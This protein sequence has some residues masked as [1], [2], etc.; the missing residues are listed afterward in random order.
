MPVVSNHKPQTPIEKLYWSF[1]SGFNSYSE[2]EF[3]QSGVFKPHKYPSIRS[4]QDYSIG[5][6]FGIVVGINFPRKE[7]RVGAYFN[8]LDSYRFWHNYGKRWIEEKVDRHLMWKKHKTK[9]S[10][11]YYANADFDENGHNWHEVYKLIVEIMVK[12]KNAFTAE[13]IL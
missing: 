9:A 5:C 7:I 11:Y 6:P 4:Y 13:V 1:W 12:M 10:A 2:L 8:N 3:K